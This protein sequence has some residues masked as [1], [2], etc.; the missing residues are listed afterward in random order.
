MK[1]IEEKNDPDFLNSIQKY[2]DYFNNN[3]Q[4]HDKNEFSKPNHNESKSKEMSDLKNENLFLRQQLEKFDQKMKEITSTKKNRHNEMVSYK[5]RD[6]ENQNVMMINIFLR[7]KIFQIIK[8]QAQ[9]INKLKTYISNLHFKLKYTQ[10]ALAR[11][12]IEAENSMIA[13]KKV[14]YK[15]IYNK[16]NSLIICKFNAEK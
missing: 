9:E 14:L 10:E 13:L 16:Y 3:S 15:F 7:N 11:E 2:I 5:K 12:K 6:E 1:L 4:K 8:Y